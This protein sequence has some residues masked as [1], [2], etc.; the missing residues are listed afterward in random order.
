MLPLG[1]LP[2]VNKNMASA[3]CLYLIIYMKVKKKGRQLPA[4]LNV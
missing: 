4:A 1:V 2:P 3:S